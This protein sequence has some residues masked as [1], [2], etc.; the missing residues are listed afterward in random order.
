MRKLIQWNL[1]TLDGYF[2]GGK[3]WECDIAV[4]AG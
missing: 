2:D 4:S 3:N 1:M